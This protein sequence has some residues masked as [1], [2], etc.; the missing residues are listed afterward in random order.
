MTYKILFNDAVAM[1]GGQPHEGHLTVQMVA[2]QVAKGVTYR[3]EIVAGWTGP[4]QVEKGATE[5]SGYA[6]LDV[7]YVEL[8]RGAGA[9]ELVRNDL[10]LLWRTVVVMAKGEGLR[11]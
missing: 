7:A 3:N 9:W 1:T 2:N 4:A 11:F 6:Q 10:G 5:S 8:C